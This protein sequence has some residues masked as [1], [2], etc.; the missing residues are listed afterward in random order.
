MIR[1]SLGYEH[2][3]EPLVSTALTVPKGSQ[4]AL[5]TSGGGDIRW[6]DDGTAPTATVGMIIPMN[7]SL[8]Y[9]GDLGAMR[10][11]GAVNIV[12]NITYYS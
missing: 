11:I 10:I 4:R 2:I 12:L 3:S 7:T 6:R 9:A 1:Q 8:L 5:L